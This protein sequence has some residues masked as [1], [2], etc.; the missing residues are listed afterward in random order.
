MRNLK[1][2]VNKISSTTKKSRYDKDKE[3]N[4][5]KHATRLPN[6]CIFRKRQLKLKLP[7]AAHQIKAKNNS[8][9]QRGT[10]KD[11]SIWVQSSASK[12]LI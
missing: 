3:K 11:V 2:G 8:Q 4:K 9:W 6:L 10:F 1:V 5:L 7:C 12:R